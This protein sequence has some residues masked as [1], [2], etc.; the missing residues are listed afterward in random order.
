MTV[1]EIRQDAPPGFDEFVE[2]EGAGLLRLAFLL[3]TEA[4]P[5]AA[6]LEDALARTYGA[7]PRLAVTGHPED[8]VRRALVHE[9]TDSIR[10][11]RS[12]PAAFSDTDDELMIALRALPAD[13]RAATVLRH[14]LDL[15]EMETAATLGCTVGAV[16]RQ[17][18][19][20]LASLR[21]LLPGMVPTRSSNHSL[22]ELM[23]HLQASLRALPDQLDV[24]PAP[25]LLRNVQRMHARK[26][27][28]RRAAVLT[29]AAGFLVVV[30]V[31]ALQ[32]THVLPA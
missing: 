16:R 30:T 4:E 20:A 3:T 6:A 12:A 7:W 13:E 25:D 24:R 21:D 19:R 2:T 27:L 9:A 23:R 15:S 11:R 18:M 5:A 28:R 10:S 31:L 22:V 26:A 1:T 29:F 32:L 8:F 17:T 14:C